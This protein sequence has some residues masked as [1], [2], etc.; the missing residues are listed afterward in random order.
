MKAEGGKQ[1]FTVV[2]VEAVDIHD[3]QSAVKTFIL[4][5]KPRIVEC[6]VFIAGG[7][8][9]GVAAAIRASQ[10]GLKVCVSEETEWIGGQMTT[11]GVS[12]P[13]ENR[14]VET[15]GATRMYQELRQKIRAH[16]GVKNPG[17]CW[18]SWCAFEPAV[19]MQQLENVIAE[20]TGQNRPQFFRRT[21]V[22]DAVIA[23]NRVHSLMAV[24]LDSGKFIQFRPRFCIDATELGDL[25][26]LLELPYTS[27]AEARAETTEPHA[28]EQANPDNVQ[29]FTYPFV[30]EFRRNESHI[31]EKPPEYDHFNSKG[32]FSFLGYRMFEKGDKYGPFWTYRRLI[33]KDHLPQFPFDLAMINW[34]ANDVRGENLIDVETNTLANRLRIGKLISLGFLHWMQTE[35]PRDDGGTGYPELK[36]RADILGTRDGLSKYPYIRESRRLKT[37]KTIIEQ[38]IAEKFATITGARAQLFRDTIGIGLY[39]IDIHG[40]QDVPGAGQQSKPFQIPFGAFIQTKLRNF[41]PACKNIGTTHITNGAYRLH[42]IEWAIGEAAGVA[43]AYCVQRRTS[44][45]ALQR[46]SRKMLHIQTTLINYG[47]PVFWF[48]DVPT[49]DPSFAAIQYATISGAL[50]FDAQT[51]HFDPTPSRR[52]QAE[53]IFSK[54]VKKAHTTNLYNQ[55]SSTRA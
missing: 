47:S 16:Y 18:V 33:A 40:H 30:V 29:D 48:D 26:P 24:N 20:N 42:P 1:I 39:P 52:A 7:G 21:K 53:S 17:D 55:V 31:I 27:G 23:H 34:E 12:A 3:A 28:P 41:L 46:N 2:D 4:D 19:G 15:S 37:R 51:L 6:D 11:Q 13:D 49:N 43:A 36:L 22:V 44:V 14:F 5:R 54:I 25:L 45:E 50:P 9:G 32:K 38:E 8:M 35:A 10:A